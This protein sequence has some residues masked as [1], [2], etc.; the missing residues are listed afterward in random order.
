MLKNV[1]VCESPC[2]SLFPLPLVKS[3][4]VE[5]KA[6]GGKVLDFEGQLKVGVRGKLNQLILP[7]HDE[8]NRTF[9]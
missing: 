3:A 4:P 9:K 1:L 2:G 5:V 6:A 7:S 8:A